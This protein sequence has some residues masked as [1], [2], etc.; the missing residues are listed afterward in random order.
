[1]PRYLIIHDYSATFEVNFKAGRYR[2]VVKNTKCIGKKSNIRD[3]MFVNKPDEIFPL[4]DVAFNRKKK[5][6]QNSFIKYLIPIFSNNLNKLFNFTELK[7]FD[8]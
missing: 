4:N 3:N 1:M 7:K 8:W 5:E 2:V 6:F